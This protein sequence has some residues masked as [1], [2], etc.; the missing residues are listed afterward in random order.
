M[1]A[2]K[3]IT[4]VKLMESTGDLNYVMEKTGKTEVEADALRTYSQIHYSEDTAVIKAILNGFVEAVKII[5]GSSL[6]D[7]TKKI[8]IAGIKKDITAGYLKSI[9]NSAQNA[10]VIEVRDIPRKE[11]I[12]TVKT[13]E[14]ENVAGL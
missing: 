4:K 3:H 7:E 6:D 13:A 5:K 10:G 8:N 14:V 1:P 11:V 9:L 12:A 2:S